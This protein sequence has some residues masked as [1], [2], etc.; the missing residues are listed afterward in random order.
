MNEVTLG[1]ECPAKGTNS[2]LNVEFNGT[3]S[4][5]MEARENVSYF[6][7]CFIVASPVIVMS[8]L[9]VFSG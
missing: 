9:F 3:N 7:C 5:A 2:D 4:K 8:M 6:G 1:P